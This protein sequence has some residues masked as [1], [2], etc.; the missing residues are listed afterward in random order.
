MTKRGHT[1]NPKNADF[2]KMHVGMAAKAAMKSAPTPLTGALVIEVD[3]RMP[4]PKRLRKADVD[5]PHTCRPD[6]DNLLKSTLDALQAASVV[7]DDCV[8]F[9]VHAVKYYANPGDPSHAQIRIITARSP[10]D[11]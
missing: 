5:I 2:W 11:E 3:F 4:R 9:D 7:A 10:L 8:F 1:Y 6:T